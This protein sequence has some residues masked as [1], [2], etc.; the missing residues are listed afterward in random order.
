MEQFPGICR[1][2]D[3][4]FSLILVAL[5]FFHMCWMQ[6]PIPFYKALVLLIEREQRR[7]IGARFYR[8][9]HP[10]TANWTCCVSVIVAIVLGEPPLSEP[11]SNVLVV[12]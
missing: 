6:R 2:D 3:R 4:R 5:L 8:V 10:A 11:T 12:V 1:R 7:F 9:V